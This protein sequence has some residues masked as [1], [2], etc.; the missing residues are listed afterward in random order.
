MQGL[1]WLYTAV[2]Q[3]VAGKFAVSQKSLLLKSNRPQRGSKRK[4]LHQKVLWHAWQVGCFG[5]HPY[6]MGPW[7]VNSLPN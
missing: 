2:T 7:E 1:G 6:T 3:G 5:T 4:K